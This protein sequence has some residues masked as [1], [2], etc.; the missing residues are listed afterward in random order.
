MKTIKMVAPLF[1]SLVM[2][3]GDSTTTDM[4]NTTKDM[5]M[6]K[7][8]DMTTQQMP[9]MVMTGPPAPPAVGAQIDRMGRAGVNTA[10]TD[11][12]DLMGNMTTDNVK[13][14]YNKEGDRTKWGPSFAGDSKT[15]QYIAGNLAILDG[16]DTKCGD[17]FGFALSSD[18]TAA[19]GFLADD[20]L[21][22]DTSQTTC[23]TYLG[24]ELAALA[25][26]PADCGGRTLTENSIDQTYNLLVAGNP[27]AGITNGITS[28]ADGAPSATFPFLT[29]P[30]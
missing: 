24:A 18:Y 28:D 30:N 8:P 21:Y 26:A 20:V 19:A 4:G 11:P 7:Q 5:S 27:A 29:P 13:D 22:V 6:M 1:A 15:H 10:L 9:D 17:S 14:A 2:G 16:A 23:V 3:C 12:F 25:G